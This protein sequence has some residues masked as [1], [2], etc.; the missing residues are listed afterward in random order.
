MERLTRWVPTTVHGQTVAQTAEPTCEAK[1]ADVIRRLAKYEDLGMSPLVI[2]RYFISIRNIAKTVEMAL[3]LCDDRLFKDQMTELNA[4]LLS[5]VDKALR[6]AD[7]N[8]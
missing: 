5:T 6:E 8:E 3:P 2:K 1:I 7:S 4:I